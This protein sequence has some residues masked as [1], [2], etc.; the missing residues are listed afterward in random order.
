GCVCLRCPAPRCELAGKW[1][2]QAVTR[3]AAVALALGLLGAAWPSDAGT[4][5][6]IREGGELRLG[7]RAD[8]PPFS[9]QNQSGQPAGY[10]VALCEKVAEAVKTELGAPALAL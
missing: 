4:L 10:S 3:A 9:Y 6:R 2:A 8:A 7:H 5:D 1:G